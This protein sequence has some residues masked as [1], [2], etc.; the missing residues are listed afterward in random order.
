MLRFVRRR[1]YAL[2][3]TTTLTPMKGTTVT[4]FFALAIETPNNSGSTQTLL[5]PDFSSDICLTRE[6]TGSRGR[7]AAW[8]FVTN[9]QVLDAMSLGSDTKVVG[10][11]ISDKDIAALN[12]GIATSVGT[13]ALIA[14][15]SVT[16]NSP[17]NHTDTVEHLLSIID[18]EDWTHMYNTYLPLG[19]NRPT[20]D[21]RSQV[22]VTTQP[23]ITQAVA[24]EPVVTPEPARYFAEDVISNPATV[25]EAVAKPVME[26]ATVPSIKWSDEYINRKVSGNLTE[27]DIY[28]SAIN[29]NSN[30]LVKGHA[31]SGKTMSVMA[32]AAARGLRYYSVSAHAGI[33]VS[34]VFGKWNPTGNPD[35]PF[36]WQDGGLTELVRNGN[37]VLLLNEVNFLPERFT[38]V[39]FSLLD[40]RREIQLMDKDGEVVHA[41]D[42][43]LIIGDMNP[44]YRG[45]R[46]MNQAWNDRF[47]QHQLNFPYD[48]AIEGKLIANKPLLD[49]ANQLRARFEKEEITT[50]ISTR[51]LV[52]FNKNMN[53]LGM[54]YAIYSYLNMFTD[55]E[56]GAVNLVIETHRANIE[57]ELEVSQVKIN[58]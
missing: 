3:V 22:A 48:A 6:Y 37:G 41:G 31:G 52:A 32:Y 24:P 26:L 10:F 50:P 16:P 8:H 49:M 58:L 40:A 53:N 15:D 55:G 12:A 57:A 14:L 29:S 39:I 36:A 45:T 47:S 2:P 25:R 9:G 44:N 46:Q 27:F 33:E 11:L 5:I 34:Q 51:A 42:N 54:D 17:V 35:K 56:R 28:D 13:K 19:V 43:L 7:G 4:T 30:V 18:D 21:P 20:S 1:T 23:V 38:T